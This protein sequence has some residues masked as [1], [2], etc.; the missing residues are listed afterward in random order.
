MMMSYTDDNLSSDLSDS[1][2]EEMKAMKLKKSLIEKENEMAMKMLLGSS[3]DDD[4]GKETGAYLML[5]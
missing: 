2:K 3:T 1:E 4:T 5:V